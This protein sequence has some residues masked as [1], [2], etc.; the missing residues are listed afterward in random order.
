MVWRYG[1]GVQVDKGT[2]ATD[3]I[4]SVGAGEGK[5][6]LDQEHTLLNYRGALWQP[7]L[8]S[9]ELWGQEQAIGAYEKRI[10][11]EAHR[12]YLQAI[13]QWQPPIADEQKLK[14]VWQVVERA[15]SEL[16]ALSY[17]D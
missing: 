5:S 6:Y 1:Q 12:R 8:L 2:L 4:H 13:K 15:K 9:R 14:A 7:E 17:G 11:D 3:V 16:A 10:L